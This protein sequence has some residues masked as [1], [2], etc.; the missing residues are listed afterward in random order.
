MPLLVCSAQRCVY[1]DGMYCS[2]GDIKIGGEDAEHVQ[3]TCC[4]DFTE[5]TA[6]GGK[7]SMGTPSQK[8][9]VSCEAC[10]CIHNDD[11]VCKAD[12]IGIIGSGACKYDQ[13]ECGTF[14]CEDQEK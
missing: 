14:N 10:N 3:D 2:K 12:Q 13:T 4:T 5:R 7:N 11:C 6:Q 1:N 8:I 9:D